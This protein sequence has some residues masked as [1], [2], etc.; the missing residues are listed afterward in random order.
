MVRVHQDPHFFT[1]RLM[2]IQQRVS[3]IRLMCFDVDGVFT[4]G[5]II[6]SSSGEELKIFHVQDGYGLAA[7]AKSGVH[8]AIIT[9]RSSAVVERRASE[10]R[11]THCFQGVQD[12]KALIEQLAAE[13]KLGLECVGH[14]GDDLPDLPA[15]ETV[16]FACCPSNA[17]APVKAVSHY[18]TSKNGGQGAVREICDLLLAHA[19]IGSVQD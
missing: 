11:F 18:E 7:L 6:Y 2:N 15:L 4:D 13:H 12:K 10:L 8:T 16:G 3:R 1:G 14:M 17:V 19:V 9:G 5:G